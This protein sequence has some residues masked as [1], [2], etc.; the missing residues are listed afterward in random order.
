MLLKLPLNT[1]LCLVTINL[2]NLTY[3]QDIKNHDFLVKKLGVDLYARST[4]MPRNMVSVG[5]VP[6]SQLQFIFN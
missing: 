3:T 2:R 5:I 6:R 4:Y 1:I